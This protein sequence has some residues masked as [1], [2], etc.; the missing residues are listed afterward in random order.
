M[1]KTASRAIIW[2]RGLTKTYTRDFARRKVHA[3][4]ALDLDVR[5]GEIFGFLGHNGAGKSTTIKLLT[6]LILPTSGEAF[7]GGARAGSVR[8]RARM[9]YLPENPSLGDA[10]TAREFLRLSAELAGMRGADVRAEID[11]LIERLGLGGFV[12]RRLGKMSKGQTQLV[13]LAHAILGRPPLLVLDEPMSGLDP[14]A[15]KA[16]RDT[17]LE[18]RATGRAVFFSSHILADVELICDRVGLV[19]GGRLA[20]IYAL[21]A[22][23]AASKRSV[24]VVAS[25]VRADAIGARGVPIV[26]VREAGDGTIVCR[27]DATDH[28]NDV[29]AAIIA[30]G[31]KVRSVTPRGATLEEFVLARIGAPPAQPTEAD[32]AHAR[33]AS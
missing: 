26:E 30:L 11:G 19:S 31:G 13:G 9:G 8:A 4:A 23:H 17:L 21:D 32:Q 14:M 3:L 22:V 5:P 25:G 28:V 16:V 20:G 2:A 10:W 6:G 7:V 27:V 24:E 1:I 12:D 29:L 15:R 33:R 18:L